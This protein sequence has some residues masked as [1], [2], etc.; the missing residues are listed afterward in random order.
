VSDE[1]DGP[2]EGTVGLSDGLAEANS[3]VLAAE[4]LAPDDPRYIGA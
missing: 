2:L 1:T 3:K 4:S